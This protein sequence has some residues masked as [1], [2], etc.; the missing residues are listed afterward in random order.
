[1]HFFYDAQS[2]PAMVEFN[3]AVYSYVHNLQGDVVG[4]VDSAGSLVVEYKYDAWGKP[5]LV[6][7]LT[8]AYEMLAE[9]NPFRY[10]GY[11]YD[12]ET[13]LY[14]LR[15]RYYDVQTCK[16]IIPDVIYQGNLY[17]YCYGKPLEH[18]DVSGCMA[19]IVLNALSGA[20]NIGLIDATALS[21]A[22]IVLN[23]GNIYNGF[24]EI[25]QLNV[26][27]ELYSMGY[28]P[29]LEYHVDG[30]GEAD[31]VA[32]SYVWEI[33]PI[34]TTAVNQPDKYLS[35]GGL[36]RGFDMDPVTEIPIVDNIKM[37]VTSS[38]NGVLHY[39]FYNDQGDVKSRDV[40]SAVSSKLFWASVV[41]AAIVGVT[42]LEDA[43][44]GGAGIS[45]DLPSLGF[46]GSVAS[47]IFAM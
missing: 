8:I 17:A 13:G 43:L 23:G 15:S 46:A 25:A 34:G 47:Y 38:G 22:V 36:S 5:T 30:V 32:G 9:L 20:Y 4:I 41:F 1:M 31:I 45:D 16:F 40:K 21:A 7:T 27:K 29:I 28:A 37:Q 42:L 24:H 12:E 44:S 26:A 14:Y 35:A 33:K 10:R 6:R 11:V 3:G 18:I 2:K 39:S 19:V